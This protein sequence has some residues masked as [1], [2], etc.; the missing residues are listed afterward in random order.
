M[1]A[2]PR[3]PQDRRTAKKASAPKRPTGP[4][5]SLDLKA[6]AAEVDESPVEPYTF[7]HPTGD[8]VYTLPHPEDVDVLIVDAL[9]R[10][11]MG[12][13]SLILRLLGD[14][15][16]EQLA[17]DGGLKARFMKPIVGGWYEWYG[18]DPDELGKDSA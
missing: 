11:P 2:A 6:L 15:Q 3:K 10:D 14:D 17:K 8:G 5:V 13:I 18:V 12:N 9:S 7:N 1:P 16:C 4:R